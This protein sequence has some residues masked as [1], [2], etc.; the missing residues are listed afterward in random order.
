MYLLRKSGSSGIEINGIHYNFRVSCLIADAPARS[1]VKGCKNHNA[2]HSCERCVDE[3]E[4][5]RRVFYSNKP[6]L[7]RTDESFRNKIDCDHHIYESPL[8]GIQLGLVG[9]VVLDY[10]H[11]ICLG[12]MK[13]LLFIWLGGP[14]M[15]L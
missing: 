9:Q 4:W 14:G 13:K 6:S 3:G 5:D 15:A 10:M 2:Y 7:L 11:C 12:V 1:F 8:E